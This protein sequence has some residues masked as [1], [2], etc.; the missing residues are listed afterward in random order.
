MAY[1]DALQREVSLLASYFAL[2]QRLNQR[3]ADRLNEMN[4]APAFFGV[5]MDALFSSIVVMTNKLLDERG[6]RGLWDFLRFIEG[7]VEKMSKASLQKRR[8]YPDGHWMLRRD[9]ITPA[10]INTDRDALSNLRC[11]EKVKLRRDK[12]HAHLDKEFFGDLGKLAATAPL[13]WSEMEDAIKFMID[14]IN[15]YSVAFDGSSFSR[16]PI[17]INDVDI[18]L[19]K[20]H[21]QRGKP[22]A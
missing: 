19:D 16:T 17:N 5:T 3:K 2:Y 18:V 8:S 20:L 14:T 7:N 21:A 6:E 11:I 22:W 4:I 9:E 13:L 10:T 12:Y 1:R 15:H